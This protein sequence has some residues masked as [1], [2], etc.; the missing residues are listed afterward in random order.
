MVFST[1]IKL[2]CAMM[3]FEQLM[4]MKHLYHALLISQ[5]DWTREY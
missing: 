4:T 5:I 3:S 2:L 1:R